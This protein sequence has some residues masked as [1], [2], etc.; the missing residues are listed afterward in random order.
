MG[1]GRG[2]G[3][4]EDQGEKEITLVLLGRTTATH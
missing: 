2:H 3:G 1:A 4:H